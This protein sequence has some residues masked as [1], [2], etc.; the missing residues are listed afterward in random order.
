MK[1]LNILVKYLYFVDRFLNVS[2]MKL[3]LR[4]AINK[5]II[6]LGLSYKLSYEVIY[7]LK[8]RKLKVLQTSIKIHFA[9]IFVS[10]SNLFL[11]FPL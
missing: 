11:E 7:S 3:F 4:L 5:Y 8:Y 1:N 6:N 10:F 9:I 2:K